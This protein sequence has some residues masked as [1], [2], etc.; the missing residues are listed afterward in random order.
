MNTL[1]PDPSGTR[2]NE[3]SQPIGPAVPDWT[4]RAYPSHTP[5]SGN[6]C[7]LEP[8][9]PDRH[10]G[11]LW[12]AFNAAPDG[13]N[14]TYLNVG[15]FA[16]EDALCAH[17]VREAASGERQHYAIVER[18]TN[19]AVGTFA[20]MRADCANGVIEVGFVTYSPRLQRTAI[21]TEAMYL[22][23]CR[24]FD[25]LGYRRLEWKCDSLNAPS[26]AAAQRYGFSYE[27]TFRQA[28]V[29]KERSRDT[30]W[31]SIIDSEWPAI[32]SAF[33]AWLA[34]E[35]FDTNG[36]QRQR[37]GRLVAIRL[38][39]ESTGPGGIPGPSSD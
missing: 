16:D 39:R 25:E 33:Q 23:M 35:N 6:T 37:L 17:L 13:R 20:L 26:R 10:T 21:A 27:G 22:L 28:V 36:Q 32:K 12:A 14:W 4:A 18:A 34:P 8:L 9:D 38:P 31:Y 11:A 29:Y 1:N 7:R 19:E 15:P 24:V 30:A 5:A 2:I 3:F